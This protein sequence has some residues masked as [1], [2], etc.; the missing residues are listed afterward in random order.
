MKPRR[1]LT[2]QAAGNIFDHAVEER[3]L[4]VLTL[5]DGA[6]WQTFKSRFLERDARGRFFVLDYQQVDDQP[7]PAVSP[8][9][10]V[11]VSFRQK[12]H[13][14][15][16][17]TIV[18]AKGHFV[19][20]GNTN[21]PAV[22]YRWPDNLTEL[23]RRAY[24]RTPVPS[25]T[26]LP[27]RLWS[28]GVTAR[29]TARSTPLQICVGNLADLSCGGAL[30]QLQ[31]PTPPDWLDGQT[32]GLEIQLPDGSRPI[33]I[34]GRYRG[35]RTDNSETLSAAVQFIGL[36]MTA[37]GRSA[38][39]RLAHSVQRLNRMTVAAGRRGHGQGF[40]L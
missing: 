20:D 5:Q 35:V 2:P 23:Q 12:G 8:G 9:L 21:V 30:I 24:F 22:R 28:G 33:L 40:S 34:D 36:E 6:G 7:L 27:A 32:L 19:L 14:L 4:A 13:K 39:Q 26:H 10:Y 38:L 15:L 31:L 11:G 17:A 25:G 3:A 37:Q 18:E 16:F 1:V 29:T